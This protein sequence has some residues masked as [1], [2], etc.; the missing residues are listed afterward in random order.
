MITDP[1]PATSSRT[2]RVTGAPAATSV[3]DFRNP[4]PV[5]ATPVAVS[6]FNFVIDTSPF[7]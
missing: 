5:A 2:S 3:T 6:L 1:A 7:W 4:D